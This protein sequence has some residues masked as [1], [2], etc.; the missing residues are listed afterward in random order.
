MT[1]PQSFCHLSNHK[2]DAKV[3]SAHLQNRKVQRWWRA[4]KKEIMCSTLRGMEKDSRKLEKGGKMRIE[5]YD[6]W[7]C[8]AGTLCSALKMIILSRWEAIAAVCHLQT[9]HDLDHLK[10]FT[11]GCSED[12]RHH[13]SVRFRVILSQ[14]YSF[15]KVFFSYFTYHIDFPS[16]WVWQSF[17]VFFWCF[18]FNQGTS[19][20]SQHADTQSSHCVLWNNWIQDVELHTV[21]TCSL[22]L[23]LDVEVVCTTQQSS[24]S[25]CFSPYQKPTSPA[26]PAVFI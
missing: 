3:C 14:N 6:S 13:Q 5:W 12:V 24:V 2:S 26:T 7:W 16:R 22:V 18:L 20:M 8:R 11:P 10:D 17:Q 1:R 9:K 25:P 23:W 15:L 4:K 21:F 19:Y